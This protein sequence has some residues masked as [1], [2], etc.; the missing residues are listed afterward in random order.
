ML[1]KTSETDMTEWDKRFM[2][3]ALYI[4]TWSKDKSTKVGCVIV[5][6]DNEIRSTGY[7]GF[8]RGANDDAGER[9][10][11]PVKYLWTEHAERNAIFSAARVG[12][13]LANCTMY[14]P[15]YPCMDC[16]RAIVQSGIK[17]LVAIDPDWQHPQWGEHF[18]AARDLFNEVG[19]D[20]V[21]FPAGTC[22]QVSAGQF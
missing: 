2:Q 5:G 20:V 17:R 18:A 4:G 14:L 6:T 3:L 1:R 19:L 16:A 11:R 15:W 8:P 7:N 9:H 13:P 10:E 12:V 21:L 22:A